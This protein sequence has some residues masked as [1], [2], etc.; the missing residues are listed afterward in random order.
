MAAERGDHE[1]GEGGVEGG[2]P[3]PRGPEDRAGRLAFVAHE[4]RN[5][6]STA[7]WT[8]ELLSRLSA[9]DRGGARGEK[10]AGMLLRSLA[11]VRQLL[12]DHLL[13]ER[14]DAGGIPVRSE[15]LG[16]RPV[17]EAA[18]ERRAADVG[19]V[20]L[21]LDDTAAV[22]ADRILLDRAVDA[23]LGAAG[24]DGAAVRASA[25]REGARQVLRVEGGQL[26]GDV[27]ADPG[28]GAPSDPR[29]RALALPTARRVAAALGGDLDVRDGG[30][31]LALPWAPGPG[32]GE[33]R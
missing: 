29:G 17:L 1:E 23:L 19:A 16:L 24:R 6:L 4:V 10:M 18:A 9:A 33:R 13:S 32:S 14:L 25:R 30:L 27:L 20:T 15:A 5:P 7:M 22:R 8:A 2:D 11:R 28:R 3:R 12:E 21:V 26:A 31:E